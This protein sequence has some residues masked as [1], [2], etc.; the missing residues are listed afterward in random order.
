MKNNM[1]PLL[2]GAATAAAAA[3]AATA[4]MAA[5]AAVAAATGKVVSGLD[6]ERRS[7]E[8]GLRSRERGVDAGEN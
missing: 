4:A 8:Y 3:T 2:G 7:A 5:T 1:E 6:H